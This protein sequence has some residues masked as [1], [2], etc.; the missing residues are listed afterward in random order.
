[1]NFDQSEDWE[2]IKL[3]YKKIEKAIFLERP[4]RF[5]AHVLINKNE[6]IVHVRN[7]GRCREILTKGTEVILEKS[8]NPNR[9]TRYSII[10]GYKGNMLINIDS[11]IPNAVVSEGILNNKIKELTGVTKLK[12]EVFFKNSRFDI[13]F[14]TANKKGFV[15]VKGVT[16]ES[17]GIA[18]FPDAPTLRGTKHVNE[19]GEAVKEGF[20]G[21]IF[22]LIQ[23]KGIEYFTPYVKMDGKFAAALKYANSS[24]VKILAYNSLLTDNEI[25]IGN[26]AK[27]II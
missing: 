3:Q 24:G 21:Y 4:N 27:V 23:I 5:I 7:T 22:F 10:S 26:E 14:E 18:M 6:E 19:M 17:N 9:K 13:Y 16:Y 1:M 15:E 8:E 11:Q 25:L 2:L 12:R 20:D